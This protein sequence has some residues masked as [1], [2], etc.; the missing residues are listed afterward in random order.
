MT[1][2]PPTQAGRILLVEDSPTQA[3]MVCELL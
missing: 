3:A 2:E 1:R